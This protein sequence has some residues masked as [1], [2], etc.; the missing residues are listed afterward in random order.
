M[1]KTN[2]RRRKIISFCIFCALIVAGILWIC[3][4]SL[5]EHLKASGQE[6]LG[7]VVSAMGG[8]PAEVTALRNT[9]EPDSEEWYQGHNQYYYKQLSDQEKRV[10]REMLTG[11]Q[12]FASE[13]YVTSGDSDLINHSFFAL[14][15]DHPELFWVHNKE[16]FYTE[17]YPDLDYAVFT[18]A[19]SYQASEV[20]VIQTS[21]DQAYQEIL[22]LLP[23]SASD[24]DAAMEIYLWLIDHVD[25]VSSEDDQSLAGSLW[26][27]QSVCAGY[28]SA[29]QYL[30]ER[31]GIPVIY[32]SG[33]LLKE[34]GSSEGHAWNIV[35]L[36]GQNYY[37]DVTNGDQ[38]EFLS[39]DTVQLE[40]HKTYVIDYFCPFPEEYEAV[41]S[42]DDDFSVP[43]CSSHELN[44]Y[45]V[46][47][48]CFDTYD[49]QSVYDLCTLR[50][51]NSAAVVRFKFSSE[52]AFLKACADWKDGNGPS[53]IANYYM[54]KN[55]LQ[56]V[57][58]YT[59][60]LEE[61][62][63]FYFMF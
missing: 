61:F 29:Y 2:H 4:P 18:P 38:P 17:S 51:D 27:G 52:E 53:E 28:A 8:E 36:D 14:L 32:V 19:Y 58:Y 34:D 6:A 3:P 43:E 20:S 62:Y 9:P 12:N 11:I 55:G 50:I 5:R 35:T 39:S 54:T 44:F 30:A 1:K 31:L 56:S 59:G 49:Y 16:S 26:K 40:E 41:T 33:E 21:M 46:N 45:A 15:Y 57:N 25:Y 13:F 63:T 7:T 42:V 60:I 24:Y 37:V 10:Y 23:E 48:A 47:Q 22:E